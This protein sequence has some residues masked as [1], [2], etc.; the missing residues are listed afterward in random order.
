VADER[1][2]VCIENI[3][4][5]GATVP[6]F[7][8]HGCLQPLVVFDYN[9]RAVVVVD[10]RCRSRWNEFSM[11][12]FV[13]MVHEDLLQLV[14]M[15]CI[16]P[17]SECRRAVCLGWLAVIAIPMYQVLLA[18]LEIWDGSGTD[19]GLCD[20]RVDCRQVFLNHGCEVASVCPL[21]VLPIQTPALPEFKCLEFVFAKP[22]LVLL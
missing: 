11:L 20:L 9:F 2:V 5:C 10:P 8:T 21:V 18:D 1:L 19:G 13:Q 17:D 14:D 7:D 6:D 16:A 3:H 12:M 4:N 22:Y 15:D